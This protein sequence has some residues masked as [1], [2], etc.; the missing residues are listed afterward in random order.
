MLAAMTTFYC[1]HRLPL[2][3]CALT[4]RVV[5]LCGVRTDKNDKK[6]T[7]YTP[8]SQCYVIGFSG[9]GDP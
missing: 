8:I 9:D 1:V 7:A 5:F 3:E 2:S 4:E 6:T